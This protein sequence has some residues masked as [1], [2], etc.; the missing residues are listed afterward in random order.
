MKG[1]HV[2][3]SKRVE[4]GSRWRRLLG[5]ALGGNG[6]EGQEKLREALGVERNG[7]ASGVLRGRE[8][9]GR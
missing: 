8:E 2:L 1:E 9:K 3:L 6:P 7:E 4:T 5:Y